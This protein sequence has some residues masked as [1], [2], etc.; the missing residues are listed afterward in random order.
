MN[1]YCFYCEVW[2]IKYSV[3][4]VYITQK[5]FETETIHAGG[6]L[7]CSWDIKP[8]IMN[9]QD[10][11]VWINYKCSMLTAVKHLFGKLTSPSCPKAF[12]PQ[13]YNSDVAVV[14]IKK[15]IMQHI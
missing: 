12:D 1:L 8:C 15:N 9:K 13:L 2:Y 6:L 3:H 7:L 5:T 4:N 10:S 14:C 11:N